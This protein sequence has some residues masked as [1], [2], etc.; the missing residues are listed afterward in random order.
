MFTCPNGEGP[1]PPSGSEGSFADV[2]GP[3]SE[4]GFPPHSE[5][6]QSLLCTLDLPALQGDSWIRFSRS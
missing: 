3:T 6:F 5:G 1:R 4:S 2:F